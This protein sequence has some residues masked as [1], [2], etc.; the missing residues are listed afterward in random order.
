MGLAIV[1]ALAG[2]MGGS[3][4]LTSQ[5]GKG[6]TVTTTLPRWTGQRPDQPSSISHK[7]ENLNK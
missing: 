3:V 5:L 6:T 1:A 4:H 2:A 7:N